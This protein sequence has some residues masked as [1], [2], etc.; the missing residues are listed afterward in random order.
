MVVN[1]VNGIRTTKVN[2]I[3]LFIYGYMNISKNIYLIFSPVSNP[4]FKKIKVIRFSQIS[5]GTSVA[6]INLESQN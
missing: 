3:L 5:L 6:P 1:I 2:Q 4:A